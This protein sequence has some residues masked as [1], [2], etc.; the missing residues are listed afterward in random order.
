M[1]T[2][3]MVHSN[4]VKDREQEFNNWYTNVHLREVL[5]IDGFI[6]AQ[7]FKLAAAQVINNQPYNY[8]ALYEIDSENITQTLKNLAGASDLQMSDAIDSASM[9]ISVFDSIH[10]KML[11][12]S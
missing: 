4:P 6:S 12:A 2:V 10:D 1:K 8:L 11:V 7:R 5:Q 3:F 9:Q